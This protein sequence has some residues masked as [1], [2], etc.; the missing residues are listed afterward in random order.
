MCTQHRP[1]AATDADDPAAA[2][3]AEL[4]DRLM[5]ALSACVKVLQE[6]AVAVAA[7]Y[8]R[9]TAALQASG[10]FAANATA[11]FSLVLHNDDVHTYQEV[12]HALR[13]FCGLDVRHAEQVTKA[14]DQVGDVTVKSGTLTELTAAIDGFALSGA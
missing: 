5:T 8:C 1:S 9:K 11:Q 3:P 14:V 13:Q 10:F 6:G 12:H 2:I 7:A 4:R